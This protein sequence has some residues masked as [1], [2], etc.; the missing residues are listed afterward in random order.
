VGGASVVLS[1]V[2]WAQ[3]GDTAVEEQ[4]PRGE[5]PRVVVLSICPWLVSLGGEDIP[6]AM[7]TVTLYLS[8]VPRMP[9]VLRDCHT[10]SEHR[11]DARNHTAGCSGWCGQWPFVVSA[12]VTQ[13]RQRVPL[14]GAGVC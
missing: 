3:F 9:A 13:G 8:T 2:I 12:N 5:Q 6:V 4:V 11:Q 14:R 1:L 7:S 10:P